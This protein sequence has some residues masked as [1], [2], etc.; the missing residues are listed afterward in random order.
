MEEIRES[1]YALM[2]RMILNKQNDNSMILIEQNDNRLE[3][4]EQNEYRMEWNEH[5]IAFV[6]HSLFDLFFSI[7][8]LNSFPKEF[9]FVFRYSRVK[10]RK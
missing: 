3:W 10:R 9:D 2:N 7:Q 1:V 8:N 6:F 4:N 5:L